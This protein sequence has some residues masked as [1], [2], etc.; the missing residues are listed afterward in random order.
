MSMQED[1]WRACSAHDAVSDEGTAFDTLRFVHRTGIASHADNAQVPICRPTNGL[2]LP[3]IFK[4]G[5]PLPKSDYSWLA[6][7]CACSHGDR[8]TVQARWY[9]HGCLRSLQHCSL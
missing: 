6:P 4:E 9:F 3:Y 2:V 5:T 8:M 1:I 7:G